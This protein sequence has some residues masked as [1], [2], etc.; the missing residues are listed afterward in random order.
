MFT[1]NEVAEKLKVSPA[2]IYNAVASGELLHHRIA[3]VS[4]IA[5]R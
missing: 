4:S 5:I 3:S 2:T 1:V